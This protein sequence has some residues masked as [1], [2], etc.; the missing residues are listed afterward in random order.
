MYSWD[1]NKYYHSGLEWTWELWQWKCAPRSPK[2]VDGLDTSRTLVVGPYLLGSFNNRIINPQSTWL[3]R[4][5]VYV[6]LSHSHFLSVC[7][8]VSVSL[9]TYIYIYIYIYIINTPMRFFHTSVADT[10]LL[11]FEC[12][13]GLFSIFWP[14]IVML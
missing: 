6:F 2:L 12:Q 3:V 11:K 7:L 1:C 10:F 4:A 13:Q 8:S 9:D 5:C 14:I